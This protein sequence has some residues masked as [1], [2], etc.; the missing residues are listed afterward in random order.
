MSKED[1]GAIKFIKTDVKHAIDWCHR[2]H[3]MVVIVP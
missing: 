3:G 1:E 2:D